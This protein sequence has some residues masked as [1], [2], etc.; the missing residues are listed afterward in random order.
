MRRRL[1][2]GETLEGAIAGTAE[3]GLAWIDAALDFG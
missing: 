2:A 1:S 3:A